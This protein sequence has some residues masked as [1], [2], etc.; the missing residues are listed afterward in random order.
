MNLAQM[1]LDVASI[2]DDLN[3]GYFTQPQ[4]LSWLN[5]GQNKLQRQLLKAGNN[6]YTVTVT[7]PLIL[8]QSA[9]ALPLD[10]KKLNNLEVIISGIPPNECTN[11]V[12]PIT[13]NQKYLVQQG[14]GT[15]NFYVI[16]KNALI[17]YPA[18]DGN[19]PTLRMT[20]S[21]MVPDLVNPTDVP[22]APSDYHELIELYAAEYA[23]MKDGRQNALLVNMIA[24][25]MGQIDSDAQERTQDQPRT[26]VQTGNN[27]DNG[28]YW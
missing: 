5:R 1:Y 15:P 25:L 8:G 26:I 12:S 18:S 4:I 24:E 2:L 11:P 22:D 7:T 6:R 23:F 17:L 19:S 13:E 10:F 21:Y 9:Y 28:F 20:Y 16:K 27:A 3:Y 14:E